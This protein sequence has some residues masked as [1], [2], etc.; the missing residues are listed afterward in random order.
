MTTAP[1]GAADSPAAGTVNGTALGAGQES[2]SASTA[3]ALSRSLSA[4]HVTMISVGGIIGAGLFVGSSAAIAGAGP[5]VVLSY[6]IAGA[7]ILLVMRMLAEMASAL[8]GVRTFTE[9]TRAGLGR[10]AGFVAG[11]LYWYFWV[12]VVPVEAIAGAAMLHMWIPQLAT[13]LLGVALVLIMTGV[14]LMSARSYGEFEFWFASIKVA[15]ILVFIALAAAYVLGVLAPGAGAAA[16]APEHAGAPG[17]HNLT[18]YGGFVARGPLA[19]LAGVATV[20]FSLTGAEI[21]TVAAVESRDP[22]RALTRMTTSVISRILLFYVVSI[23]LIV[24]VVP[25]NRIVPGESPFTHAL[26]TMHFGW[27]S[28]FMTAIILTAVLSCLNSAFYVTSRV[29]FTLAANHDAPAWLVR[30]NVR[31]VPARSVLMGCAAGL[32]GILA[33]TWSYS[34]VFAFLI[35]ASGALIVFVYLLTACAQLRLRQ[36]RRRRGEQPPP[37]RMWLHPWATYAAI[38][39]ML[40]V[41]AAMAMTPDLASQLYVSVASLVVVV[42]VYRLLVKRRAY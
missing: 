22:A 19:V 38:L 3:P 15:A 41:L 8:P 26:S 30:L 42:L 11:W 13:P 5:A 1:S 25:W 7:L 10:G 39:G 9:F 37:V 23:F 4:R 14:N 20:F 17:L 6:L 16:G 29:L 12:I 2:L 36:L 18:A 40:A 35:N 34:R 31:R 24:A 32:G 21:T 27:A 33:A 28:Q